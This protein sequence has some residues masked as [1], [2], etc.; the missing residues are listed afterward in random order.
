METVALH[1]RPSPDYCL[2]RFMDSLRNQF[3]IR[4]PL[5]RL[6]GTRYHLA[7]SS[8]FFQPLHAHRHPYLLSGD[9]PF[10]TPFQIALE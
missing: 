10:T 6:P 5:Y 3:F 8:D 2:P 9:D 7:T 4:H 1:C